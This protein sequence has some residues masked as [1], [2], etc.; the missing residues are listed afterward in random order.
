VKLNT[1]ILL[2][3]LLF[4]PYNIVAGETL[5][6]DNSFSNNESLNFYYIGYSPGEVTPYLS[7]ETS[8]GQTI[9]IQDSTWANVSSIHT[10]VTSTGYGGSYFTYDVYGFEHWNLSNGSV[11]VILINNYEYYLTSPGTYEIIM[12]FNPINSSESGLTH[13]FFRIN[14]TRGDVSPSVKFNYQYS[15][16][17]DP[18]IQGTML[19]DPSGNFSWDVMDLHREHQDMSFKIFGN[20]SVSP[21]STPVPIPTP[22]PTPIPIP[23]QTPTP[24]PTTSP[25]PTGTIPPVPVNNCTMGNQSCS[26][27]QS[28][29]YKKTLNNSLPPNSSGFKDLLESNGYT[30]NV[31]GAIGFIQDWI[32]FYCLFGMALYTGKLLRYI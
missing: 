32:L 27:Y 28:G 18:Y 17:L 12:N 1:F 6:Y 31:N 3:C 14:T 13:L 22:T 11:D 4:F 9:D 2:L 21:G 16:T 5:L 23:T 7:S 25:A 29:D 15:P 19:Q 8:N 10:F 20:M 30:S 26:P 24:T